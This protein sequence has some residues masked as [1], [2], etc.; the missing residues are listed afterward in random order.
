MSSSSGT[1]SG[2]RT[3]R[4]RLKAYLAFCGDFLPILLVGLLILASVPVRGMRIFLL[5]QIALVLAAAFSQERNQESIAYLRT[6][7]GWWNFTAETW[8]VSTVGALVVWCVL[9]L[10]NLLQVDNDIWTAVGT[11]LDRPLDRF[12]TTHSWH[13]NLLPF[14]VIAHAGFR[15]LLCGQWHW[16]IP[17]LI[18]SAFVPSVHEQSDTSARYLGEKYLW[19]L[20]GWREWIVIAA[21][22]IPSVT[23]PFW[24]RIIRRLRQPAL[25]TEIVL[26]RLLGVDVGGHQWTVVGC[27]AFVL[28][29][30]WISTL[31]AKLQ[32][33][34]MT[35]LFALALWAAIQFAAAAS[36]LRA[37][38]FYVTRPR[39]HGALGGQRAIFRGA[40]V[41]AVVVALGAAAFFALRDLPPGLPVSL[42]CA[43]IAFTASAVSCGFLAAI[44]TWW[45]LAR[46][47][48]SAIM[49]GLVGLSCVF[50]PRLFA[51]TFGGL[52][53][54]VWL[55]LLLAANA[56]MFAAWRFA[57]RRPQGT[58]SFGARSAW[59]AV[60]ATVT[61]GTFWCV[62]REAI[63][64][65]ID[66]VWCGLT[67]GGPALIVWLV[68]ITAGLAMTWVE[69][70]NTRRS[71]GAWVCSTILGLLFP[72]LGSVLLHVT[73]SRANW[74]K[75]FDRLSWRTDLFLRLLIPAGLA[76]VMVVVMVVAV[77]QD[78]WRHVTADA[79]YYS[80]LH[81]LLPG[82]RSR[83]KHATWIEVRPAPKRVLLDGQE[84]PNPWRMARTKALERLWPF[85]NQW[86]RLSGQGIGTFDVRRFKKALS[87]VPETPLYFPYKLIC[88][89]P[90]GQVGNELL[91]MELMSSETTGVDLAG[92]IE[93]ILKEHTAASETVEN[94][95]RRFG[96]NAFVCLNWYLP[97]S[98][99]L[100]EVIYWNRQPAPPP[101]HVLTDRYMKIIP[102][103]IE[104]E[105]GVELPPVTSFRRSCMLLN[106][107]PR[108]RKAWRELLQR[109]YWLH[110]YRSPDTLLDGLQKELATAY[111][112]G[113]APAP[114]VTRCMGWTI[115]HA[116]AHRFDYLAAV[117]GR[118]LQ[119]TLALLWA[120][121]FPPSGD[122]WPKY[123]NVEA[124]A[125][126]IRHASREQKYRLAELVCDR[127]ADRLL[128]LLAETGHERLRALID[129]SF[130]AKKR[131][132]ARWMAARAVVAWP[133]AS[134]LDIVER[135]W[136]AILQR[137]E[138]ERSR[139]REGTDPLKEFVDGM[140]RRW[141]D[142][143]RTA[144]WRN[145]VYRRYV[146]RDDR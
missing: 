126:I 133:D 16:G 22:V 52:P 10:L 66:I 15:F 63:L 49:A 114:A 82:W 56:G 3:V 112:A 132:P 85:Y 92:T 8:L 32:D 35:L 117:P 119:R 74:L 34:Q 50:A 27:T 9:W 24:R 109:C 90:T 106:R 87:Y 131:S 124:Y 29:L 57:S 79:Y 107:W 113:T 37:P 130:D 20:F 115:S 59:L 121:C 88:A 143:P 123:R 139:H 28:V 89:V 1:T 138:R 142:D 71:R 54:L 2:E 122:R 18:L 111:M 144:V 64:T 75:R 48:E 102:L 104:R 110:A 91:L 116:Y 128:P 101:P 137:Y 136:Q 44:L 62:A 12:E 11:A 45:I 105:I 73:R 14:V 4:Q 77:G 135:R 30:F 100:S 108:A 25:A 99:N 58:A 46:E 140:A 125:P 145:E 38:P 21:L 81:T 6:R 120:L 51:V 17:V 31:Q 41:R 86:P 76:V 19:H 13:V 61:L 47:G 127:D 93:T 84:I 96:K 26:R 69:A 68:L 55:A 67:R 5:G 53:P 146:D 98:L 80:P 7:P 23:Y 78:A 33:R 129:R 103:L 60:A 118:T 40:H 141:P 97:R 42:V 39:G 83:F 43:R 94:L 36:T 72:F 65:L 95:Y 70:V 134:I